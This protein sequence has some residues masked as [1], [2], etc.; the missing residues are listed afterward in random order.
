MSATDTMRIYVASLSD[1]N[2]GI[3]HGKWIEVEDEDQIREEIAAMLA[4]S[5]T[6]KEEGN[7]AEEYAI[8]DYEGFGD[9]R[10]SEYE[11]IATI[12]KL[13][14]GVEEHGA[15][16][17]AWAAHSSDDVD[18]DDFA[19][20]FRGEWDSLAAYVEDYWE[21]CGEWKESESWWHPSRYVDWD[22]LAHDWEVSGDVFTIDNPEGGVFVF[23]NN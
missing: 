4:D 14:E 9:Y 2:A 13:K 16:F 23:D 1:Y 10:L 19:E 5:P 17:L 3:L 6:A 7:P 15:A 8:H 22:R 18:A 20:H 11:D 21:Q 12:I